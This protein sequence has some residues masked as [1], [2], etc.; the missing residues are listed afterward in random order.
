MAR[1]TFI[2]YKFSDAKILRNTIISKLGD[3]ARYYN[4]ERRLNDLSKLADGTIT[5]DE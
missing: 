1:K 3:D 2:S 5:N 4:G